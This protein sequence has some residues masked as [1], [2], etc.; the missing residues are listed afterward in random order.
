VEPLTAADE[1]EKA[2]LRADIASEKTIFTAGILARFEH[3]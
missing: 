3:Y 1:D 2:R